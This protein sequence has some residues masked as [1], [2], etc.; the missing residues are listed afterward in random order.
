MIEIQDEERKWI[1]F[2]NL[3]FMPDVKDKRGINLIGPE[4]LKQFIK[5]GVIGNKMDLETI[6]M[7]INQTLAPNLIEEI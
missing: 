2:G 7:H 6:Q 3:S 4:Y 5:E 1:Y